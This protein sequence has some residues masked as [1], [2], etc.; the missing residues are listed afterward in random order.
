MVFFLVKALGIDDRNQLLKWLSAFERVQGAISRPRTRY[1]TYED[2][3]QEDLL[4]RVYIPSERLYAAEAS[5]LLALF[6]DWLIATRG[7]GVRQAE[8]RTASGEMYEFYAD[9]AV[10]HSDLRKE[11]DSF[12]NFLT[13]CTE[14]P[15]AAA[16]MLAPTRLGR[17]SSSDLVARFSREVRRLQVDLRHERERR[18]LSLKHSLEEELI[19]NGIDL[20]QVPSGQIDTLLERLVPGPSASGSWALLAAPWTAQ[21]SAPVTVNINPQIINAME[22]TII[23]NVQ[24]TVNLGPQA[25]E[26]LSLIDR[27]GGQEVPVLEAAVHELEDTDARPADRSA[28]KRRLKKFLGQTAGMAH[29]VGIH[30]LEKYLDSK[31]GF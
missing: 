23:Q 26:L 8:Y 2:D 20:R 11:F 16:D 9:P 28:A 7:H 25:K 3:E 18:I 31:I 5:R 14:N 1:V 30:L 21:L 29:D 13:L 19:D 27:F 4:F 17:A 24:G 15:S 10:V 22:S 12:S 6:R